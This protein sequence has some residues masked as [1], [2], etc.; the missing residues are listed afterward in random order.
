LYFPLNGDSDSPKSPGPNDIIN[1][2]SEVSHK[3][4]SP[5]INVEKSP[6]PVVDNTVTEELPTN[7]QLVTNQ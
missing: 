6:Q 2:D 5:I 7:Q 3:E 4:N 1:P